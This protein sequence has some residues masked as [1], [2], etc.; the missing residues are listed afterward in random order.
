M[1]TLQGFRLRYTVTVE[2]SVAKS[3]RSIALRD[4]VLAVHIIDGGRAPFGGAYGSTYPSA[5]FPRQF[6]LTRLLHLPRSDGIIT[7]YP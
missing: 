4:G 2:C 1:L 5:L 6:T 7:Q 3:N